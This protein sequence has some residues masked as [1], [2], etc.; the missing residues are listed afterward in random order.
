MSLFNKENK[1]QK[2]ILS[3]SHFQ[4]GPGMSDSSPNEKIPLGQAL[5]LYAIQFD[6]IITSG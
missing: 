6:P 5:V 4:V 1:N 3:I 2:K